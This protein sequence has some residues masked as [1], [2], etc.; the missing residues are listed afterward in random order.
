MKVS[1][2]WRK[3]ENDDLAAVFSHEIGRISE[4]KKGNSSEDLDRGEARGLQ[5]SSRANT[6]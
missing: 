5:E 2:E 1:F 6:F 4:Y 3:G